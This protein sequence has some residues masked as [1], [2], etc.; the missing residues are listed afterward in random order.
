MIGQ[1]AG[2]GRACKAARRK[3]KA[4]GRVEGFKLIP[5]LR[6]AEDDKQDTRMTSRIINNVPK[7]H[8]NA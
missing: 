2:Q 3:E 1:S 8:S 7:L 6:R 4:V 5:C